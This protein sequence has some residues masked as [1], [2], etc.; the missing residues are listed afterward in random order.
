[1]AAEAESTYGAMVLRI[2]LVIWKWIEK[3]QKIKDDGRL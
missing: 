1:M 2:T 3:L